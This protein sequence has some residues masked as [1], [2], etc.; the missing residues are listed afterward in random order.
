MSMK[1]KIAAHGEIR[2]V[3]VKVDAG[4]SLGGPD[5]QLLANRLR[6]ESRRY[7]F[8]GRVRFKNDDDKKDKDKSE[9]P[10]QSSTW[11]ESMVMVIT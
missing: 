1:L 6:S 9:E 3:G 4:D 2:V 5:Q 11:R 8:A 7:I 10:N